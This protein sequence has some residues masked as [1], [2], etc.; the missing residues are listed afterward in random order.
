MR[1]GI[2]LTFALLLLACNARAQAGSG[3]PTVSGGQKDVTKDAASKSKELA[4]AARLNSEVV[5]LF[6]EGKYD[7]A[8][9]LAKQVLE[10]REKALGDDVLVV[11]ALNN[12]ASIYMEKKKDGDAEPL[13]KRALEV[14]GRIGAGASDV[15]AEVNT[16]LGVLKLRS[17]D[18]KEA[19]PYLL[20]ALDIEEKTHGADDPAIVPALFNLADLSFYRRDPLAMIS[21]LDRAVTIVNKQPPKKD[22]DTASRLR[23]YICPIMSAREGKELSEKIGQAMYRLEEPEKAAEFEKQE[24]ERAARGDGDKNAVKGGVL[25][26]RAISKVAPDYPAEAKKQ[27]VMGTVVL[28]ITVDETGK[29][30][31]AEKVCGHPLLVPAAIAAVYRWRFSPTLLYGTPVKVTGTVTVNFTLQ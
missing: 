21:F 2:T 26:G 30:V 17:K 23:T 19:E 6:G 13:Y 31:Q 1:K 5:R 7:E 24:K 4:E 25:A 9:P 28:Q 18:F 29:V 3:S 15:A 27:R 14:I 10:I 8:L 22:L 20:R 11:Y 16:H 12:L